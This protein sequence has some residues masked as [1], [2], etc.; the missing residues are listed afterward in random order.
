MTAQCSA[1]F[2]RGWATGSL[3]ARNTRARPLLKFP[4]IHRHSVPSKTPSPHWLMSSRYFSSWC[5]FR[6]VNLNQQILSLVQSWCQA[7]MA[8]VKTVDIETVD[9]HT[10]GETGALHNV[11]LEKYLWCEQK[12][13]TTELR[14]IIDILSW[15]TENCKCCYKSETACDWW[16]AGCTGSWPFEWRLPHYKKW[17]ISEISQVLHMNLLWKVYYLLFRCINYQHY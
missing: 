10:S 5:H 3:P 17:N 13:N 11:E 7:H 4:F 16:T 12:Q 14:I 6:P 2:T 9:L 1:C 15:R 8:K